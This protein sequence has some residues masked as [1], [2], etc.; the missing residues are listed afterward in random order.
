MMGQLDHNP[1][2]LYAITMWTNDVEIFVAIPC[3]GNIPYIT[4]FPLNEGGLTKAL[5]LLRDRPK[6]VIAPTAAAPA[7]YTKPPN[8][9][10]VRPAGKIRERLM[11]ETTEDQ[12]ARAAALIA[13]MLGKKP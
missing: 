4:S 13:Q 1:I 3:K 12:R 11:A 5:N 10:Q 9:P 6:E 8:Q 2:P 7:N